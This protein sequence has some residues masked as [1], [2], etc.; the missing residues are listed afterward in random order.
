M[1]HARI[2]IFTHTPSTLMLPH[3]SQSTMAIC[4]PTTH[5]PRQQLPTLH[6]ATHFRYSGHSWPSMDDFSSSTPAQQGRLQI[7]STLASPGPTSFQVS[8]NPAQQAGRLCLRPSATP[9]LQTEEGAQPLAC[10]FLLLVGFII[11]QSAAPAQQAGRLC[12]RPS[13]TPLLRTE[14]GA[15]QLACL[16]LLRVGFIILQSA[17]TRPPLPTGSGLGHPQPSW[18]I[19]TSRPRHHSP[20]PEVGPSFDHYWSKRHVTEHTSPQLSAAPSL[21]P[22]PSN[23]C[24]SGQRIFQAG[25]NV[26]RN[27]QEQG[28]GRFDVSMAW[29]STH[30]GLDNCLHSAERHASTP[31]LLS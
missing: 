26:T 24:E 27:R 9:L 19:T 2:H 6:N 16:F 4:P 30:T 14:E 7:H 21:T 11:L 8:L 29:A 15:Q 3:E 22:P 5:D 13:A 1:G 18:A 25:V 10:L 17:A 20:V 28:R 12:L 23:H 31:M